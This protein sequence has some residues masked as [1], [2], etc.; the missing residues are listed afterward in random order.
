MMKTSQH[1]TSLHSTPFIVASEA[2]RK[3]MAM[4]ERVAQRGGNVLI[5]GETGT[6]K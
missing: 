3:F 6:G 5:V 4:V 1:E 2:M